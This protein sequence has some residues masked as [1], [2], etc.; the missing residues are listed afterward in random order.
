MSKLTWTTMKMLD[1]ST[2]HVGSLGT[3]AV[4]SVTV[5]QSGSFEALTT[6]PGKRPPRAFFDTVAEAQAEAERRVTVFLFAAGLAT[7]GN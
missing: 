7:E 2:R 4:A 1:G 5:A 3:V 6:L